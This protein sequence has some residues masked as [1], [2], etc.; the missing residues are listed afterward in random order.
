[1]RSISLIGAA[2]YIAPRHIQAIQT[3]GL[4][5][6][7]AFDPN[8]ARATVHQAFP[9]AQVHTVFKEFAAA[10]QDAPTDFVVICSPN[11]LHAEQIE[12]ALKHGADV[13]CE[14]P[15]VLDPQHLDRLCKLEKETGRKVF[16][17]LQLRFL[18]RIQELKLQIDASPSTAHQIEIEY[19][20]PRN[21]SYFQSWKGNIDY[22][23]GIVTNIGI[24]LFDLLIWIFGPVQSQVLEQLE[25]SKARGQITL[26]KATV[27]WFL[28]VDPTDLPQGSNLF[29]RKLTIDEQKLSLEE[30]LEHL[31]I[32]VYQSILNKI[33]PGIEESRASIQ[34]CKEL[35]NKRIL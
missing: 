19:I 12:W 1:M 22:S 6:V 9:A 30:G 21:A 2:G 20:T 29:H 16:T 34:F 27:R 23:G 13:I 31:H 7:H 25:A 15:L 4:D 3:V 5:L 14:K 28:S 32:R 35:I 10:F 18:D 26:A 24:H 8:D 11:H 33:A 17:V